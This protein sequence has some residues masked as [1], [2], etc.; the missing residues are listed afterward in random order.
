[1]TPWPH[2]VSSPWHYGPWRDGLSTV[3]TPGMASPVSE[4]T[5]ELGARVRTLRHKGGYSQDRFAA[6]AGLDRSYMGQIERGEKNVTI[7]TIVRIAEALAVDPSELVK[8]L[9]SA[10]YEP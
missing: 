6:A 4:V 7:T 3:C 10:T 8:G 9:R 2:G 5:S 1:M